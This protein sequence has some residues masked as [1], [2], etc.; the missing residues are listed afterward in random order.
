MEKDCSNQSL[1]FSLSAMSH[2]DIE[3]GDKVDNNNDPS[4]SSFAE[5]GRVRK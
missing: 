3:Y 1:K 2:I 5:E 4:V